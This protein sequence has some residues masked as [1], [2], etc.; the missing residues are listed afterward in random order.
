MHLGKLLLIVIN[1]ITLYAAWDYESYLTATFPSSA[2]FPACLTKSFRLSCSKEIYHSQSN[3]SGE[4]CL[5]DHAAHKFTTKCKI[6]KRRKTPTH[7]QTM[8][9]QIWA[10]NE[11]QMSHVMIQFGLLKIQCSL[12]NRQALLFADWYKSMFGRYSGCL[13]FKHLASYHVNENW[14]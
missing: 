7:R 4:W 9:H 1:R 13:Q 6:G 5:Q 3:S 8:L 2:I 14:H 10:Y 12:S 11:L